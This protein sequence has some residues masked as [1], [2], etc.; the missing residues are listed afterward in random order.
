MSLSELASTCQILY[1]FPVIPGWKSLVV[2]RWDQVEP[3]GSVIF[4]TQSSRVWKRRSSKSLVI[5][6]VKRKLEREKFSP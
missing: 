2:K 4:W 1:F 3:S 6:S 5:I